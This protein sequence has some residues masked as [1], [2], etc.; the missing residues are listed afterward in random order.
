MWT[1]SRKLEEEEA[2]SYNVLR[3]LR[4]NELTP[5]SRAPDGYGGRYDSGGGPGVVVSVWAV[6]LAAAGAFALL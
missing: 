3:C 5:G 6:V 4:A 1:F 2:K